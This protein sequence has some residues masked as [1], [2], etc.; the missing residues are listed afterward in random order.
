MNPD[1]QDHGESCR[2]RRHRHGSRR[3]LPIRPHTLGNRRIDE[4]RPTPQINQLRRTRIVPRDRLTFVPC[5]LLKKRHGL[6]QTPRTRRLAPSRQVHAQRQVVNIAIARTR[7]VRDR[8]GEAIGRVVVAQTAGF[9]Q[10][11][12]G[13]EAVVGL[14]HGGVLEVVVGAAVGVLAELLGEGAH[15]GG[16]GG[17]D[18]FAGCVEGLNHAGEGFGG[19]EEGDGVLSRLDGG[20]RV[21]QYGTYLEEKTKG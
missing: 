12:I 8:A 13:Q 6:F 3:R 20:P 9:V 11:I 7:T 4:I 15:E 2:H 5:H 1:C 16:A 21:S 10:G 19:L 14:A 18:D 17:V